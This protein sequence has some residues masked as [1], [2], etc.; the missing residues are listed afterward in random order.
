MESIEEKLDKVLKN[1]EILNKNQI[2]IYS[3]ILRIEEKMP[4]G[5]KEFLR[6]YLADIAGTVT[7]ELGLVDILNIIKGK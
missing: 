1:Q 5:S 7:A 2:A 6:N 3:L 4:S